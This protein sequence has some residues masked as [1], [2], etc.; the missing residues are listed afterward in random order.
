VAEYVKAGIVAA[1]I[2]SALVTG[3]NQD[4]AD[5]ANRARTLRQAWNAAVQAK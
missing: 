1:G 3:P 4:L 5:L 2:G